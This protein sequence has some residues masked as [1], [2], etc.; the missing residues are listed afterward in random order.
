MVLML[1]ILTTTSIAIAG[2]PTSKTLRTTVH[3]T[4]ANNDNGS[5]VSAFSPQNFEVKLGTEVTFIVSNRDQVA[6]DSTHTPS[7]HPIE[8]IAPDGTEIGEA[9]T[10]PGQT[11]SI[12]FVADQEGDYI[13]KCDNRNCEAHRYMTTYFETNGVITVTA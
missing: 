4:K 12:T 9:H 8:L 1:S 5:L 2:Q 3:W 6:D 11:E 10:H 7:A 13:F